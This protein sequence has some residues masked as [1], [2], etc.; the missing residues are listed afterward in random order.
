MSE[1]IIDKIRK[2]LNMTT[3]NGCSESEAANAAIAAARLMNTHGIEMESIGVKSENGTYMGRFGRGLLDW[4][5]NLGTPVAK[6]FGCACYIEGDQG[7]VF[8]GRGDA[9]EAAAATFEFLVGEMPRI[10]LANREHIKGQFKHYMLGMAFTVGTRLMKP[11]ESDE[12][13]EFSIVRADS[14][15]EEMDREIDGLWDCDLSAKA[16]K[17]AKESTGN[18]YL[19]GILDGHLVPLGDSKQIET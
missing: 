18:A 9:P 7:M 12:C 8:F 3:E 4:Q 13:E 11:D 19:L 16:L 5:I 2:L 10:G 15:R 6:E 17:R 14:A 1:T